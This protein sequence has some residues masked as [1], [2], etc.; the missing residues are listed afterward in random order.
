MKTY[1]RLLSFA[2]PIEKYAIPYIICT[3]I[4]VVFSTLNL[5]LLAPLLHTLFN[6]QDAVIE[7]V[8][9]PEGFDVMGYFNYYAYDLNDRL[10]AYDALKY[11]CIVIVASVFISNL[12]RYLSQRIMENLRIHTLLNLRKS[13]F[14]NVMN[15]HLGYFSNQ[16]KG[17]IISK[18]A[19]DVQ[20]VQF[21]VTGT[22]QVA[23]KEPLQL[24]AYLVMLFLISAKLTVFSLLVIPVSA[25]FISKIVKTLKHQ[26]QQGQKIYANMITLLE[27]ALS[28]IKIIKS[29][30]AVDFIKGRFNAEND[31]Y[32]KINRRMVRRQQMGSPVSELLG[33]G[34]VA[35]ILLYGGHLVLS[36][37]GDLEASEF[38]AY[39]AIFSQVMR[40]AKALTD[41]FSNIHN[42]IAAG[43]RVLQLIDEK[44]QV[45]DKPIALDIDRFDSKIEFNNVYFAYEETQVLRNINLTINKGETVALVGPSGGGKS[46][47]VDLIPRFMDATQG[48][49]S[50]DGVDVKD[51]KQ[52]SLRRIIGVVN[53]ESILFND[54]IF[55][56][57]AFANAEATEEQVIQA[58]KIANAH[59][60][61]MGTE[62][63]Y[64]TNI[65]DR[66]SKLSGGQRQRI[67]IARAVLKNP[68][69]MLLDEATSALDTESERL[70]QDSLYK[71]ME[72]RTTVVIAHRLSTIQNADKI[73]VLEAGQIVEVGSHLNLIAQNGLYKR[74]IDMQ[75]FVEA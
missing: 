1:F 70:V 75:Q 72:N 17:D 64:Q 57:I 28:G 12:F 36:G 35:V 48:A 42:G 18:I 73:I 63:G 2:K 71:L 62:A 24:I 21:S 61:I 29:F 25:F 23:F 5:A 22:L 74:L 26:A 56:N 47:L 41:A 16:R 30:N 20:V 40:P 13:V 58:A 68:P 33:V 34:M 4:M 69:I 59:E 45:A 52:D 32:A 3:L 8:A 66:G 51:L 44:N 49:I 54:T 14:D 19:S 55:N 43:E 15:L 46:T 60:F 10:G 6:S 11:V 7:P 39:I 38:I 50:I 27:E 9:K 53:Q 31:E 37:Q 65:G 67:C